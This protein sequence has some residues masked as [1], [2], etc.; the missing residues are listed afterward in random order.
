MF[1]LYYSITNRGLMGGPEVHFHLTERAARTKVEGGY[2]GAF[3]DVKQRTGKIEFTLAGRK[4]LFRHTAPIWRE[5]PASR[6]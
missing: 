4:I 6:G 5:V 3:H 1:K 2:S